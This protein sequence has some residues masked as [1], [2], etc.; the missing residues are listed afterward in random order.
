M[1]F[2]ATKV[3]ANASRDSVEPRFAVEAH[4]G[5]LFTATEPVEV[6][7]EEDASEEVPTPLPIELSTEA[8]PPWQKSP[9][10]ATTGSVKLG[11]RIGP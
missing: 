6:G 1:Y 3:E 7:D 9:R 2:D 5:A 11:A 10:A 4:L 8:R